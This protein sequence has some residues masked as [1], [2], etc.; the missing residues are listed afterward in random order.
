M[1]GGAA[2][3]PETSAQAPPPPP[4]QPFESFPGLSFLGI[5]KDAADP[6]KPFAQWKRFHER[7]GDFARFNLLGTKVLMSFNPSH[8]PEI[9]RAAG[10][11]PG[12]LLITPWLMHEKQHKSRDPNYA[13]N[14]VALEGE[15]WRKN[16]SVLDQVFS[17]I[18]R[19]QSYLP[20]VDQIGDDLVSLLASRLNPATGQVSSL[21]DHLYVI[22]T[23]FISNFMILIMRLLLKVCVFK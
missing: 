13:T 11:M 9:I 2:S 8:W 16:R 23:F 18:P 4:L 12:P 5:L 6:Q 10:K 1:H 19:V 14:L 22:Y 7:F 21:Y 3:K 20:V 17:S 15:E